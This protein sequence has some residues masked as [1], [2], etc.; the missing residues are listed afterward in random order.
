MKQ[1]LE[2]IHIKGSYSCKGR[3]EIVNGRDDK[4]SNE[5]YWRYINREEE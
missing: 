3:Y 1:K 4:Y 2:N 5:E